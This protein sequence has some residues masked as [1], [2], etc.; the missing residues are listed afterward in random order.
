MKNMINLNR[1]E[2]GGEQKSTSIELMNLIII[3]LLFFVHSM[4]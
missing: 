2:G 4:V 1:T 3:F